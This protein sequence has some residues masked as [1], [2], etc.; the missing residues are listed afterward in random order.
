MIDI[1]S[2]ILPG[3]DDGAPD[4]A[5]SIKMAK[6]AFMDGVTDI[7]ATPHYIKGNYDNTLSIVLE[8]VGELN[9]ALEDNNLP[10]KIYPGAELYLDIELLNDILTK[11]AP[12]LNN[13]IYVLIELPI[14]SIPHGT[15]EIIFKLLVNKYIPVIAHPE[16]NSEF[17]ARPEKLYKLIEKGALTQ[18]NAGSLLGDFGGRVARVSKLFLQNKFIHFVGSDSH[19]FENRC[20]KLT[21]WIEHASHYVGLDYAA[22]MT[23]TIPKKIL[24]SKEIEFAPPV[25]MDSEDET[26]RG[27]FLKNIFDR[28]LG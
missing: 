24:D 11:K 18:M 19:Y 4:M 22:D 26:G 2:H 17:L 12:T 14:Q 27:G 1:H 25:L 15:E 20:S 21:K 7:I 9:E 8:K 6:Q 13:G 23:T 3:I 28:I 5:A 16:R 10:V